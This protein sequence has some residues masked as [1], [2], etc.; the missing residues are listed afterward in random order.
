MEC[1]LAKAMVATI[2]NHYL[3]KSIR[4]DDAFV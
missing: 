1:F 4:E 3:L 2:R